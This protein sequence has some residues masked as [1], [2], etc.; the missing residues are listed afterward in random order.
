[1]KPSWLRRVGRELGLWLQT[2]TSAAVY[3]TLIVTFGFQVARVEGRSMEP[4][5]HDQD[6]LVVNKLAYEVH[7]PEVGDVVMLLHPNKPELCLVKRVVAGPGDRVAFQDGVVV[8]NGVALHEDYVP[9]DLRSFETRAPVTVPDG[10]Y[11]V[12]GDQKQQHGQPDLRPGAEAIHSRPHPDP[13]VAAPRCEVLRAVR[14]AGV[15]AARG[16]SVR[17]ATILY[18]GV[19]VGATATDVP[20][21]RA[22]MSVDAV[23]PRSRA[24]N[25][26]TPPRAR[27]QA[28]CRPRLQGRGNGRGRGAGTP[29]RRGVFASRR[30]TTTALAIARSFFGSV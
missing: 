20:A 24:R 21:W 26:A 29:N 4:T 5:L 25:S 2:L 23:G 6:R 10:Y 27:L 13:V 9:G 28:D 30:V 3:T 16:C 1:M 22:T 8:R 14:R 11:F 15:R 19:R 12:L 7:D 17:Q 18:L